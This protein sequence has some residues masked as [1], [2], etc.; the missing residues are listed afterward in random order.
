MGK[1]RRANESDDNVSDRHKERHVGR[2]RL[3]PEDRYDRDKE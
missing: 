2:N 1:N 3:D